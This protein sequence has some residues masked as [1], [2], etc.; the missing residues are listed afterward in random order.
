ME[1]YSSDVD[2][3]TKILIVDDEPSSLKILA[4]AVKNLGV[5]YT[6][7]NVEE[8]VVAAKELQPQVA[9]LDIELGYDN[10]L[11]LCRRLKESPT[12]AD[13]AII[14]VTSHTEPEMKYSSLEYGGIGFLTKPVDRRLCQLKVKN[15]I[16]LRKA[17]MALEQANTALFREKELLKVTLNSIGD[18]VIA[19][20]IHQ[21]ITFINPIAERMTGWSSKDAIGQEIQ[22]VMTLNDATT[23]QP[24]INPIS[25]VLKE[26][27]VVAMALNSQ[28]ISQS[29]ATYRVENSAAPIRNACDEIIGAIIVFHDVSEAV[30][31]AIKMSYLA[32]HDQLT[33]LPNRVLLHDRLTQT[34]KA[35]TH[36]KQLA[37]L[38]LV[39]IDHFKYLNDP[40][41]YQQGDLLIKQVANRLLAHIDPSATLARTGGDEF[42]LVIPNINSFNHVDTLAAELVRD[43]REPFRLDDKEYPITISVGISI[44]PSDS[45]SEDTLMRNAEVAMYRAKQQGR[46]GYC[47][48]SKELESELIQR[49]ELE[50]LLRET[51][52]ADRI[53]VFF[54][55]QINLNNNAIIATEALAR[56]KNNAGQYIP[57]LDFIPLA[58]ELGLIHDLGQQILRKSC[59]AAK[60]WHD[61]GMPVKVCVNISVKQFASTSFIDQVNHI[62]EETGICSSLLELEVTESALMHDFA[63]VK[64]I[65]KELSAMGL[66]IAIDDFGTGYSSLSYLKLFTVDILKIDQSFVKDML[67]DAQSLDIVKT[68]IY[69]AKALDL[70]IVAEGIEHEQDRDM[71]QSL[72]CQIGQGYYFSKPIPQAQ[73]DELLRSQMGV[74]IP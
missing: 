36:S 51:I 26:Q 74:V 56:L 25:I 28:L 27:R 50:Q 63:K 69:L 32:N 64:T 58:E 4:A 23:Q 73:F 8:A 43:M 7:T 46:N 40:L 60:Q 68:I 33:N 59:L 24:S 14:F 66:S 41:G 20:D 9:I 34:I 72:G 53:E 18:A 37:A 31:I 19:T 57:P 67:T 61:Q 2:D 6:T 21:R 10:G 49:H 65:L 22:H 1:I 71:L 47:F 12:T 45:S 38:L 5:V 62:I 39:D 48:F 3:G 55:P 29:G 16:A 15:Q 35:A 13:I 44:F 30:A 70:T 11:D 42:V 52:E 54:Q 17:S